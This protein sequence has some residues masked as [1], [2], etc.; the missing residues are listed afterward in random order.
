MEIFNYLK[1]RDKIDIFIKTT[2]QPGNMKKTVRMVS[3]PYRDSNSDPSLVQPVAS[4]Y[5][6]CTISVPNGTIYG[7]LEED[8]G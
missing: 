3:L 8:W 5:T 4:C 6:N 2:G 1:K 7:E